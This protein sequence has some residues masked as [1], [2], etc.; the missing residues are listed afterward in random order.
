MNSDE[1]EIDSEIKETMNVSSDS[2]HIV[3]RAA[4]S[5]GSSEPVPIPSM[6]LN[7]LSAASPLLADDNDVIEDEWIDIAKRIIKEYRADPYTLSRALISLRAEY[8][9]KR[10]NKDIKVTD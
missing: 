6:S 9:K 1:H 5:L 4:N 10:Y 7:G 8:M 3:S 2:A